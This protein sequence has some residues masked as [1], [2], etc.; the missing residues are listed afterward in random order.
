MSILD[1]VTGT[2][3]IA[4][5]N[6]DQSGG[7]VDKPLIAFDRH[8]VNIGLTEPEHDRPACE[9]DCNAFSSLLAS[10]LPYPQKG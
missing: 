10:D 5:K 1:C 4:I 7:M 2:A 6:R 9:P 8:P 3:G